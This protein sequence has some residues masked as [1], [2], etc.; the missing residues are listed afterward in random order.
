MEKLIIL[1][2]FNNKVGNIAYYLLFYLVFTV[3]LPSRIALSIHQS[4]N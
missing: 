1:G 2:I 4:I 3:S